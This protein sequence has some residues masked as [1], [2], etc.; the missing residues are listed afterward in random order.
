MLLIGHELIHFFVTL[1][2]ATI[3]Y[4]KWRNWKLVVWV[5]AVGIFLDTDH[6]IDCY[7][8]T[9]GLNI[10]NTSY[11]QI[12]QKAYVFLHSWEL[13]IPW[14]IY[15]IYSKKFDLGLAVTLVF[16]GHLLVDQF[17][18]STH[19]LTYFL[20]YRIINGFELGKLFY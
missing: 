6:I 18:Y 10:F 12:S 13:L 17:S 11:F 9:G 19:L 7:L 2:I 8:A 16:I 20:S 3:V 1:L 14:W 15:I 4:L 5:F